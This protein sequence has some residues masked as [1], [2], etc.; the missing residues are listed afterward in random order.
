[1]G[2]FEHTRG[3]SRGAPLADESVVKE[4]T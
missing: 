3:R 2:S 1:V 4:D